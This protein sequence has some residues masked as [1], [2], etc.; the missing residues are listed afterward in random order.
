MEPLTKILIIR[1]SS[2]GDIIQCSGVPGVLKKAYPHDNEGGEITLPKN[3]LEKVRTLMPEKGVWIAL[4]PA[5]AWPKKTWPLAYWKSLVTDLIRGTDYSL[6]I[7]GGPK[8]NFCE[9]LV[10]DSSRVLTLQG[11]LS[12]LESAAAASLCNTLIAADTGLLHMA[13]CLKINVVALIGPTPF[14]YPNRQ[15]SKT[16]EVDLWCK[17]CSKDGSGPCINPIYQKCMKDI[18]PRVALETVKKVLGIL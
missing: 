3:V 16:L 14:G 5:T 11:K 12:L 15:E 1:L 6:L 10:L 9:E 13:E 8:D 4:A 17:P 18:T 2:I 7:L